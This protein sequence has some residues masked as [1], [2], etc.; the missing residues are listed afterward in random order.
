[1]HLDAFAAQALDGVTRYL[2]AVQV[3][4]A[5]AFKMPQD[6]A[7]AAADVEN[8]VRGLGQRCDQ[9]IF[10]RPLPFGSIPSLGEPQIPML[11]AVSADT[12]IRRQVIEQR[13]V[14]GEEVLDSPGN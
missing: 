10:G 1:M 2:Q 9:L 4:V 7:V 5:E 8:D 3:G 11:P 13:K 6:A 14:F 12:G